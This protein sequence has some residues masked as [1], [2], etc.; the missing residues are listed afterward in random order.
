MIILIDKKGI[1]RGQGGRRGDGWKGEGGTDERRREGGREEGRR[2]GGGR[3]ED[4]RKSMSS[5]NNKGLN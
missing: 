3:K 1:G 5:V 4:L 2:G